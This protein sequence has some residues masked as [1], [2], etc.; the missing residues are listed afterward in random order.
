MLSSLI[1][2]FVKSCKVSFTIYKIK[3][4]NVQNLRNYKM[5]TKMFQ[6]QEHILCIITHFRFPDQRI[7]Q[8]VL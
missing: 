5:W 3:G 1:F 8:T 2:M 4:L 6:H 7:T